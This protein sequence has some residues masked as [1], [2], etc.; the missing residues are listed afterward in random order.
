MG[1]EYGSSVDPDPDPDAVESRTTAAPAREGVATIVAEYVIRS[2]AGIWFLRFSMDPQRRLFALGNT[3]GEAS[4]WEVDRLP[5]K[6]L[7]SVTLP[8]APP[9]VRHTAISRDARHLV[10]CC[11][12]A[13]VFV[14]T[15]P[16]SSANK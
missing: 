6:V 5:P 11:D 13:S 4:V 9:T 1:V 12:D 3:R 15:L 14:W 16:A 2:A 8:G 10:C 7:A